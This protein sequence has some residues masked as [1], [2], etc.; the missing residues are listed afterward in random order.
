M[1]IARTFRSTRNMEIP[2]Y[3]FTVRLAQLAALICCVDVRLAADIVAIA[4]NIILQCDARSRRYD[5]CAEAEEGEG[6]QH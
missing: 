3:A 2:R 4:D 6:L 5:G 1:Q